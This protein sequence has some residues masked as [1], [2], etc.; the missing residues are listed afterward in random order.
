MPEA[1]YLAASLSLPSNGGELPNEF[2]FLPE[3][4]HEVSARVDGKAAT[5]TVKV[6]RDVLEPLQAS[7]AQRLGRKVRPHGGFD[8]KDGG[9]ASFIPKAFRYEEG[10]GVILE[11]DWTKAGQ[12]AIEGR[13]Y[14]YFSPTFYRDKKTGKPLGLMPHGE[15]GSLVNEPAFESIERI[16]ASHQEQESTKMDTKELVTLGLC[17]AEQVEKGENLPEIIKA[18]I[19]TATQAAVASAVAEA[20]KDKPEGDLA[21]EVDRL[22]GEL[23]T[24]NGELTKATEALAAKRA[25]EADEAI[26]EAVKAGRIPAQDEDTNAFWKESILNDDT[27]KAK[28]QLAKLPGAEALK[29]G[30]MATQETGKELTGL[31]RAIAAHKVTSTN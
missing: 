5:R 11:V 1:E 10:R 21:A 9:P 4:E 3:G 20:T 8:H 16:A 6:D 29:A 24:A 2:V 26:A 30:R 22:K 13:N 27:G 31:A 23:S 17:T 14:S 12:E 7:L 28:A 19:A 25:T 15:I 18:S